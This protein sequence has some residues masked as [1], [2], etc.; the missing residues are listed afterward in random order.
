MRLDYAVLLLS[1][2]NTY[3][4]I[5]FWIPSEKKVL[6]VL[7]SWGFYII[8]TQVFGADKTEQKLNTVFNYCIKNYIPIKVEF[9]KY[10]IFIHIKCLKRRQI[11]C[12]QIEYS[13]LK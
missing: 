4:F 9:W 8:K 6:L 2:K 5:S 12:M 7:W 13:F 11:L 10:L 1:G 3:V